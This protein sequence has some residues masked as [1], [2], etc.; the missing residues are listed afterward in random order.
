M[1]NN[2]H[3]L[4]TLILTLL[5]TNSFCQLHSFNKADEN[6]IKIKFDSL[7]Y[8]VDLKKYESLIIENYEEKKQEIITIEIGD[9]ELS[10]SQ[11]VLLENNLVLLKKNGS[12]YA[13][14]ITTKFR[15]DS[16]EN[17]LNLIKL[18][19]IILYKEKLCGCQLNEGKFLN[20]K[21]NTSVDDRFY[22]LDSNYK[23]QLDTNVNKQVFNYFQSNNLRYKDEYLSVYSAYSHYK[24]N[25]EVEIANKSK[26]EFNP[27]VNSIVKDEEFYFALTNNDFMKGGPS[28]YQLSKTEKDNF[29][30]IEKYQVRKIS[31][32]TSFNINNSINYLCRKDNTNFLC[33]FKSGNFYFNSSFPS[34][35]ELADY[36]YKI[37]N[38]NNNRILLAKSFRGREPKAESPFYII[39]HDQVIVVKLKNH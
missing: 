24:P 33:E 39:E 37:I 12:C 19:R 16:L 3:L 17:K 32:I 26:F 38:Q 9:S 25:T 30:F 36:T 18:D 21:F 27:L 13:V 22:S 7:L 29:Q 8:N 10:P 35:N 5:A 34:D 23:W 11:P 20:G 15:N 6:K 1:I 4:K 28:I 31:F 2:M 14:D